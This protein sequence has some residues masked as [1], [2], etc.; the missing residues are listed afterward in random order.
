MVFTLEGKCWTCVVTVALPEVFLNVTCFSRTQG[1]FNISLFGNI[2]AL[3]SGSAFHVYKMSTLKKLLF[4]EWEWTIEFCVSLH[5]RSATGEHQCLTLE[6]N[7]FQNLSSHLQNLASW[8]SANV[9][10][11]IRNFFKIF[12]KI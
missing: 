1:L 12:V 4:C 5:L 7:Q 10:F 6:S 3:F 8:N 2:R 11:R 9:I